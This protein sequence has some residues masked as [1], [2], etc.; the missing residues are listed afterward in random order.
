VLRA[1]LQGPR[2]RVRLGYT[3]DPDAYRI[4]ETVWQAGGLQ[5]TGSQRGSR[6]QMVARRHE[7]P[8]GPW[9]GSAAAEGLVE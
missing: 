6:V 5:T 8:E 7:S 4:V 1:D 2:R 9:D 3:V